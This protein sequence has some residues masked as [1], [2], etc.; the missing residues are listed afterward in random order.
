M[1]SLYLE[2]TIP[3]YLVG[4]IPGNLTVAAHQEA[5]KRWWVE[6]RERFDIYVSPIVVQEVRAGD[7]AIARLRLD[8]ISD[9]PRVD[10]VP[11]VVRLARKLHDYLNL[12]QKARLDVYHLALACHWNMDYLLTWNM[13][14]LANAQV[15]LK[16]ARYQDATGISVPVICTPEELF[17]EEDEP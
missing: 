6:Q 10:I 12:P 17:D 5:T 11:Q 16:L 4:G 8:L 2:T 15:R 9:L 1:S 7:P 13:R 3:S 14:H